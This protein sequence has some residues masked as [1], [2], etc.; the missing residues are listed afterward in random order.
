MILIYQ[1][2]IFLEIVF[3]YSELTALFQVLRKTLDSAGFNMTRIVAADG[4]WEPISLDLLAD[5]ALSKAVDI[6]G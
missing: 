3:M 2:F 4:L 1:V 6:I 5:S